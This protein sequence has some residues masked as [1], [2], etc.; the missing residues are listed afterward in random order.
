MKKEID[1]VL[2]KKIDP[3]R[4]LM[5][6]LFKTRNG[7]VVYA[8]VE[9][10]TSAIKA[11]LASLKKET[12]TTNLTTFEL[13]IAALVRTYAK[14]PYLNRYVSNKK[15]YARKSICISFVV[16]KEENHKLKESIAKVYF[17]REDTVFEV[18]KKLEIAINECRFQENKDDDRLMA[19][20]SKLPSPF[21]TTLVYLIERLS[22]TSLIPSQFFDII[23]LYS[24]VFFS[25][26]G[27][28]GQEAFYHHL[29]DW[30]TTSVF[31][32]MGKYK[33]VQDKQYLN[34]TFSID[35]RIADGYYLANSFKYFSRLLQHPQQLENPPKDIIYDDGI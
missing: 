8:P 29:Y 32:T 3:M 28:I 30:G 25:N 19:F 12:Q 7:S 27:S 4:K 22:H 11:Y 34:F 5:P 33:T 18:A 10:E 35:E 9:I 23:P 20:I 13:V 17:K 26:L 24:S 31:I 14:Y 1:G 21:I 6:Y 15:I 2:L 16:L